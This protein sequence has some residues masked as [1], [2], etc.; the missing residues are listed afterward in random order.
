[1]QEKDDYRLFKTSCATLTDQAEIENQNST[2]R[3]FDLEEQEEE[4][5][6]PFADPNDIME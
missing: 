6:N 2:K 4:E 1:M 5:N 3:N